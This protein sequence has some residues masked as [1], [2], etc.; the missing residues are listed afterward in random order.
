MKILDILKSL[1]SKKDIMDKTGNNEVVTQP[2]T[3]DNNTDLQAEIKKLNSRI[4]FMAEKMEKMTLQQD[5]MLCHIEQVL[6][7]AS[8]SFATEEG[9]INKNPETKI[10]NGKNVV[11][12]R[13][14]RHLN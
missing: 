8:G 11:Q 12:I 2:N 13:G 6:F 4:S 3:V 1:F 10:E 5:Q 7:H 14:F 9:N